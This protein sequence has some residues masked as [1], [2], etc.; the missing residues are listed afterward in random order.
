MVS[1][2]RFLVLVGV[3]AP[4]TAAAV[5]GIRLLPSEGTPTGFPSLRYGEAT[6]DR[7]GMVISDARFA[8]AWRDGSSREAYFDD[9]ACMVQEA[10][11][12]ALTGA[13]F[14]VH[15]HDEESWLHANEAH[16]VMSD[17][18]R[19][20]MA[21][22][23]AAFASASAAERASSNGMVMEWGGLKPAIDR[24]GTHHGGHS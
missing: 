14:F 9:I 7:C 15:D 2:R 11:D 18:I 17:E 1:R 16:F 21:S 24:K 8:A 6:C 4:V 5:V 12:R 3:G 10:H 22:G 13:T 20:P 23:I 19:T